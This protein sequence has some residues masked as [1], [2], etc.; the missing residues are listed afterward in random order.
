MRH[1]GHGMRMRNLTIT[2]EMVHH[3]RIF[4]GR[5]EWRRLSVGVD[6][7]I[8]QV[9]AAPSLLEVLFRLGTAVLEPILATPTQHA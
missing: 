5:L 1:G 7:G 6:I 3:G 9:H 4:A 2:S 8:I